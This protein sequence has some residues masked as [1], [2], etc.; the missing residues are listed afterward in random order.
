MVCV[1]V[2]TKRQFPHKSVRARPFKRYRTAEPN[3]LIVKPSTYPDAKHTNECAVIDEESQPVE[4]PNSSQKEISES[5]S[6]PQLADLLFTAISDTLLAFS[7][8]I[9]FF[10]IAKLN[11]V[12]V[13]VQMLFVCHPPQKKTKNKQEFCLCH[14]R[15]PPLLES[16]MSFSLE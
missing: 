12:A 10:D 1:I 11:W 16:K 5:V 9:L 15:S 8:K 7:I 6:T 3:P 4:Q 14:H 2:A 13:A